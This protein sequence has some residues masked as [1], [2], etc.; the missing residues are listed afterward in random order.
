[1]Q[2]KDVEAFQTGLNA[3]LEHLPDGDELMLHVSGEYDDDT[4]RAWR[5]VRWFLGLP[6]WLGPTK[7][8]Q[9]AVR[10]P[11]TRTQAAKDRAVERRK[12][13]EMKGGR[14]E[15]IAWGLRQARDG[16]KEDPAESNSGPLISDWIEAGGGGRRQLWCQYFVNAVAVQGGCPQIMSGATV[17]VLEGQFA[18][19]GYE[20][21]RLAD[22]QTGDMVFFKFSSAA[23]ARC[24]HVGI[25]VEGTTTVE[26]N[27]T[28]GR[29]GVQ[30]NGGGVF[31]RTDHMRFA[32]GAVR[33]PYPH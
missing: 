5:Q 11:Q 31:V 28:S 23:R 3:R 13:A 25:R 8:A 12:Q 1:M 14:A 10:R 24:E 21:I 6:A 19:L 20:P 26:G 2:G 7:A 30:N 9:L 16:V 27:T 15:A 22:A 17:A 29:V 18:S 32:V 4:Q 33:V